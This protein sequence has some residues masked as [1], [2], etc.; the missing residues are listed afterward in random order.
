MRAGLVALLVLVSACDD[1]ECKA[2][3]YPIYSCDPVPVGSAAGCP[4]YDTVAA[5][6][7]FWS[8]THVS[9]MSEGDGS[10]AFD[11]LARVSIA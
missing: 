2:A 4:A 6:E 5:I 8:A 7:V 3:D 1:R 9:A 10:F 11:G